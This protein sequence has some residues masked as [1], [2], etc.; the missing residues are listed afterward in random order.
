[1]D[2]DKKETERNDRM[3]TYREHFDSALAKAAESCDIALTDILTGHLSDGRIDTKTLKD[4]TAALKDLNG[5][6][7]GQSSGTLAV[8]F[9]SEAERYGC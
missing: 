2:P 4:V 7:G 5:L 9:S 1:M 6:G 3:L 8:L